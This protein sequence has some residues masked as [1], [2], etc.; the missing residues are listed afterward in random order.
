MSKHLKRIASPR[1]WPIPRKTSVWVVK[2]LPGP[3][4]LEAGLP[5]LVGVRDFLQLAN[6]AT[7]AR[8]IIGDGKV[9]VDG[10]ITRKYKR[11]VGLMD[12][13]SIPELKLHYRVLLD[14]KGKL[15]FIKI[16]K[17]EAKWK[18]VRIENKSTV[19]G[20]KIQLNLHDGRN[21]LLDK[22]KYRSGD[23]LKISL[24]DQKIIAHYSFEPGNLVMLIGGKHVGEFA[25]ITNYEKIKSPKP[26]IVF[27][28]NFSTIK[29]H[30]FMVGQD[31][32][33][34]TVPDINVLE[35]SAGDAN[36]SAEVD[37]KVANE[38]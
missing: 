35:N 14:S 23:V 13:I 4:T 20:G 29:D 17:E 37:E 3:H 25:T 33:E 8:R 38:K 34:I 18:L 1:K 10:K 31:K 22:N 6:T 15:R 9:L 19:K 5:L 11:P 7:E 32:P 24:P 12:V 26:N 27:F 16:K 36:K 21:I 2:S 30:V 28:E